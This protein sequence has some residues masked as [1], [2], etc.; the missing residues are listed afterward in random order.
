MQKNTFDRKQFLTPLLLAG[1]S[2]ALAMLYAQQPPASTAPVGAIQGRLTWFDRQGRVLGKVGKPGLYRTM[3]L[4]PDARRVAVE[5]TD[6]V[7][8]NRDIWVIDIPTGKETQLT[9]DPAWDAFPL[10]SPDGS[11]IVFTSNRRGVFDLYEK[12][13]NGP[14]A[15]E[16]FYKSAEGKGPTSWSPDGRFLL[17]YS[18]GQPTHLRLLAASG[19]P[20]RAPA[21]FVDPRFSSITARFSPNG[22]WIAYTSNESSTNEVSVRPFDPASGV[23]GPP[24]VLSSGGGRTPLWRRDSGE[25]FYLGPD[26]SVIAQELKT[27]QGFQAQKGRPLSRRRPPSPSGT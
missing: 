9:S 11:R 2:A 10:W 4:S 5:R 3:M 12:P 15:E 14:G 22:R 26:G 19:P 27:R 8:Q 1:T 16:L 18:I 21:P 25:L 24:V 13:L 23:P 17:F 7:T 20:D 6:P